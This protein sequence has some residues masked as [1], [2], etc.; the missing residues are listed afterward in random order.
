MQVRCVCTD[1]FAAVLKPPRMIYYIDRK[2]H[3]MLIY[4]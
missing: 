3:A 2:T 4:L 1:E